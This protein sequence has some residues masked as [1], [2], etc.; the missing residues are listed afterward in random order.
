MSAFCVQECLDQ[1][2]ENVLT[3]YDLCKEESNIFG[4]DIPLFLR[5]DLVFTN[6]LD[7]A[8]FT[9]AI[10]A[11]Q[12]SMLP[13]GTFLLPE[14]TQD[15]AGDKDACGGQC[16]EEPVYSWEFNTFRARKDRSDE[17][18]WHE[19]NCF[20]RKNYLL[21]WTRCGKDELVLPVAQALSIKEAIDAGEAVPA[22]GLGFNFSST[23][24]VF[25]QGPN[26][27]RKKGQWKVTGEFEGCYMTVQIPGLAAALKSASLSV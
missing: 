17:Q 21:A 9:S 18:Y 10:E 12:A 23:K 6:I 14:P 2:P 11:R 27:V 15:T 19:Y 5:C 3:P 20:I 25:G 22:S 13:C 26:G 1:L 8:E 7:T 16:Y 24:A 4:D